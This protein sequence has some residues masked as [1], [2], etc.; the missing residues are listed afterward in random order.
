MSLR[1]LWPVVPLSKEM[2][3][4]LLVIVMVFPVS[5]AAAG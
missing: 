1:H 5:L 3:G 4:A 2:S